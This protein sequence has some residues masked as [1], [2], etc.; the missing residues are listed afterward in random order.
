MALDAKL[1]PFF[2]FFSRVK[3]EIKV[4]L[5]SDL[6][7]NMRSEV[8]IPAT[9]T[10]FAADTVGNLELSGLPFLFNVVCMAV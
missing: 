4:L 7:R 5:V 10:R 1:S 2:W 9:V 8:T 6:A 3:T